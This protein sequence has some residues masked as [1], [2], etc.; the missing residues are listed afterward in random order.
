MMRNSLESAVCIPNLKFTVKDSGPPTASQSFVCR[1]VTEGVIIVM[2][3][4]HFGATVLIFG[5]LLR[6][7]RQIHVARRVRQSPFCDSHSGY[8]LQD[9]FRL[10]SNSSFTD[11][12]HKL[13]LQGLWQDLWNAS[14]HHCGHEPTSGLS[15]ERV[16]EI[17]TQVWLHGS[18]IFPRECFCRISEQHCS[19]KIDLS[20]WPTV[21]SCWNPH[22]R[23]CHI[24]VHFHASRVLLKSTDGGSSSIDRD[25]KRRI[26]Q[27]LMHS[28]PLELLDPPLQR[29]RTMESEL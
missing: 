2:R 20:R 1:E 22:E 17:F 12:S 26:A 3:I 14:H 28:P 5:T 11:F 29:S 25:V 8:M 19:V 27:E 13:S 4:A 6:L 7:T 24:Q 15:I 10:V 23:T 21:V 18:I 9:V 16:E